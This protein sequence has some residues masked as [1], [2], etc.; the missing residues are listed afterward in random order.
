MTDF[1]NGIWNYVTTVQPL[2]SL[3]L[4]IIVAIVGAAM[5]FPNQKATDWAKQHIGWVIIGGAL[6][7]YALNIANDFVTNIQYTAG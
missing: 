4:A 1:A 7:M 5:A 2:T 6:I 3:Y